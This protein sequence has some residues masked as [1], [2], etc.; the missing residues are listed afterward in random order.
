MEQ[1]LRWSFS[2]YDLD[3]NGYITEQ[4]MLEIVSV[5]GLIAS[6]TLCARARARVLTG[7]KQRNTTQHE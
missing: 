6:C 5:S 7:D 2:M 3:G 4:E 1:K